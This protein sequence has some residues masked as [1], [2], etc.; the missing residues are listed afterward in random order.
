MFLDKLLSNRELDGVTVQ[1]SLKKVFELVVKMTENSENE[2]WRR[3]VDAFLTEC[4]QKHH[5]I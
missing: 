4:F 2:K 1:Y 3:L 5:N